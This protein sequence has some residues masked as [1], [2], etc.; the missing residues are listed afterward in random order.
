[1]KVFII[2]PGRAGSGHLADVPDPVPDSG[3]T[4]V[5]VLAVGVDA[6]DRE[7]LDGKY[8][9]AAAGADYL[10]TGH[11]SLGRVVAAPPGTLRPG[12]LVVA[13]VRRPDPVPLTIMANALRVGDHLVE[14]L[15]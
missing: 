13:I 15:W 3:Q 14:R 11:E 6:T 7:L 9:E 4:R 2:H 8:G 5:Q 12:E 10:I 1:M